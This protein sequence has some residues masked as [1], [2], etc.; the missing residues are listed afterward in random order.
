MAG[1]AGRGFQHWANQLEPEFV[2][3]HTGEE[4]K[5]E[6]KSSRVYTT[7]ATTFK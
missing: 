7:G 3:T 6:P 4:K 1:Q 2:Y 5:K